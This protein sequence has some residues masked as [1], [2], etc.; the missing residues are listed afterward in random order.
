M[1]ITLAANGQEALERLREA[2]FDAVLMDVQMPVMDGYQATARIRQ[3]PAFAG[4]PIIAMTAHAMA[5]DREKCLVAGMNDYVTKPI[6]PAE[7]FAVLAKW[8]PD[9][10]P[11][12]AAQ[13]A[14]ADAAT[15]PG[16]SFELGLQRCMGRTELYGRV[17][18]RFKETRFGDPKA[19]RAAWADNDLQR[20][21]DIAHSEISTAGAIGAQGLS[22]AA[23]VLKGALDEGAAHRLPG[24]LDAFAHQHALVAVDL[25][26][27]LETSAAH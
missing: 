19:L 17:L 10:G 13:A 1:E 2:P 5:R 7:L 11:D 16:I 4:L 14:E 27:Y 15:A 8:L 6:D 24:L 22:E 20:I 25:E 21:A 23:R 3:Q 18:Q 12:D 9:A 26:R